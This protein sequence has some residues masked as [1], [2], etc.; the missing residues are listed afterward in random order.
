MAKNNNLDVVVKLGVES[1]A[2]RDG[3]RRAQQ[4]QEE[5]KKKSRA[6]YKTASKDASDSFGSMIALAKKFA[7]SISAS[8]AALKIANTAMRENQTITDEWARVTEAARSTYEGFVNSLVSGNL[9][10]FFSNMDD[11]IAKAREAADAF[12]ALDTAKLFSGRESA[13]LAMEQEKHLSILRNK[14][15]SKETRAE[16]EQALK[17]IFK[18]MDEE[19]TR[20]SNYRFETFAKRFAQ[21][22]AEH[23]GN[24]DWQSIIRRNESGDYELSDS[25]AYQT[26]F[27]TLADYEG[28]IARRD[29][30]L[31]L[32]SMVVADYGYGVKE[33]GKGKMSDAEFNELNAAI[34]MSDAKILELFSLLKEAYNDRAQYYRNIGRANRYLNSSSTSSGGGGTVL[35]PEGSIARVKQQLAEAQSAREMATDA[36]AQHAA[37][38][39]V[40]KLKKELERLEARGMN[41]AVSV[42]S[43]LTPQLGSV[44]QLPTTPL[45]RIA[46]TQ[47]ET[48]GEELADT[49]LQTIGW[50]DNLSS[51]VHTLGVN[52]SMVSQ[53]VA[54]AAR[55]VGT[56]MSI[57]ASTLGGPAGAIVGGIGSLIGG[58][59]T[60]GIVGGTSYKG[61]RLTA[62]VSSGEMI[63]NRQQQRNLFNMIQGGGS[64]SADVMARVTGE[65]LILTINNSLRRRGKN[66]IG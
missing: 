5:F 61:D 26:Y 1:K 8:A 15:I 28:A 44:S 25:S 35:A 57:V 56:I 58:F 52:S 43:S 22:M 11:M 65:D 64:G 12:D 47:V 30:E 29:E 24:V 6:A 10:G 55:V 33:Y 60:G 42:P 31:R 46:V 2:L 7:P 27:E 66:T 40:E 49:T 38:L 18:Q 16:S 59:D 17:D 19:T 3:L 54:V 34:E 20:M 21:N 50:L 4:E 62:Q 45:P 36:A 9:S 51:A 13:R 48:S 39:L 63:L 41:A 53:E 32:R 37:E 14:G 23:G